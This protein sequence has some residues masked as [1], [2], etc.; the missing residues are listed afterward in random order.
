ML[1]SS[2]KGERRVKITEAFSLTSFMN[3][4]SSF[5]MGL[6]SFFNLYTSSKGRICERTSEGLA[7]QRKKSAILF[8]NISNNISLY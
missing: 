5:I 4:T 6:K 8:G 7:R 1:V 3:I 2:R